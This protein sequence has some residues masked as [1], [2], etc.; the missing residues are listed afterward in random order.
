MSSGNPTTN[1]VDISSEFGFAPV[2]L[3]AGAKPGGAAGTFA[4][5][6]ADGGPAGTWGPYGVWEERCR[7]PTYG[8]G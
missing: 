3:G 8:A 6:L 1:M 2:V 7:L 4:A 5:L